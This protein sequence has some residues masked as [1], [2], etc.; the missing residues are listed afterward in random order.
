VC[1][2]VLLVG[3]AGPEYSL[4]V[5]RLV[6]VPGLLDASIAWGLASID[7]EPGVTPSRC[8]AMAGTT[9]A[10]VAKCEVYERTGRG[11]RSRH[12]RGRPA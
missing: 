6:V 1:W 3:G 7:P 9:H 11:A 8:S 5:A 2:V 4:V 12:L 10:T